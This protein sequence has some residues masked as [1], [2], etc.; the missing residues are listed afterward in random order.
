MIQMMMQTIKKACERGTRA[1]ILVPEASYEDAL[2][3]LACRFERHAGRT[4][5]MEGGNLL[6]IL[7]PATPDGEISG[8][9]DLYLS[10][11]GR[12][13]PKDERG[14]SKWLARSNAVY[15]EVS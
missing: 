14:M 9:F 11:W 1:V 15:T 12:A 8:D 3:A 10:G 5:R 2:K 7:T 4:A 6:T 13:T